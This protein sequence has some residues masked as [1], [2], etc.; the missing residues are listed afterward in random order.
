MRKVVE[1]H[2]SAK[3]L[4]GIVLLMDQLSEGKFVCEGCETVLALSCL[5]VF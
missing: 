2:L 5:I 3:D 1:S 4:E